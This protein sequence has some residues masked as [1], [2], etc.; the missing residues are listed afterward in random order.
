MATSINDIIAV[1]GGN[2]DFS[3]KI[4]RESLIIAGAVIFI[5]VLVAVTLA[6]LIVKRFV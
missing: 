2:K 4:E 1:A 3:V 5:S 6:Q